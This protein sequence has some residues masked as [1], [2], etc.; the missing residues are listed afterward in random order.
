VTPQ[1]SNEFRLGWPVVFACAVGMALG[2]S[3]LPFYTLGVF[4]KPMIA[5]FGWSRGAYQGAFLC[6]L[7]GALVAPLAGAWCDR[8]GVRPVA[9]L[10]IVGFSI[11]LAL[12]GL[13]T[14]ANVWTLYAAWIFMALVSQATG[15]I[16]WTRAISNWFYRQRGLAIGIALMGSGFT[17]FAAPPIAAAL[18]ESIGWR[19]TYVVFGVSVLLIA[20]P[21]V[22]FMLKDAPASVK[23]AGKALGGGMSDS[24]GVTIGEALRNYRFWVIGIAFFLVSAG[25]AGIVTSLVPLLTDRGFDASAAAGYASIVGLSVVAGRL[26][27]G[28]LLDHFWG[29]GVGAVL[30]ALPA[31]S[32]LI[33]MGEQPSPSM[34]ILAVILVGFAGGAEFDMIAYFIG[35]YFGLKHYGKIYGAQY[36]L[37]FFGAGL[38]P[39]VFGKVYDAAQSYTPILTVM[40][41]GFLLSGLILLTLGRYPDLAKDTGA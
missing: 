34:L 23:A 10:S 41:G 26:I 37:V 15:P 20:G 12:I 5:E 35:R 36:I 17:A 3:A 30:M 2:I 38:A 39:L 9:M 28:Y 8:F 11:G 13:V 24:H 32:C 19:M 18:I 14:T 1:P 21:V 6:M 31:L 22:W 7:A 27:G 33:L 4:A 29:P 40:V 25:V 16:A